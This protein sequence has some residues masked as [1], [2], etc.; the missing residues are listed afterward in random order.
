MRGSTDCLARS[1][2]PKAGA[3]KGEKNTEPEEQR[4]EE[5]EN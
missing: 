5:R 3:V 1:F 4:E 2:A